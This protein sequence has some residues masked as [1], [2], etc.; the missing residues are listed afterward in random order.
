MKL[1]II[2]NSYTHQIK[3]EMFAILYNTRLGTEIKTSP[4]SDAGL[5]ASAL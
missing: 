3:G 5:D 2:Y 4:I 1:G